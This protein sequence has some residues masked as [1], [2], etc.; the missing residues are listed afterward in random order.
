MAVRVRRG[1]ATCLPDS[2]LAGLVGAV[3]CG[4]REVAG[5]AVRVHES[6][7]FGLIGEHPTVVGH[8]VLVGPERKVDAVAGFEQA[9]AL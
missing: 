1:P 6:E 3:L 8:G 2:A 9:G 4:G 5:R 7:G